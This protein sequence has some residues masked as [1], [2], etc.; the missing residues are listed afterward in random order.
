GNQ[1]SFSAGSG[2]T[3]LPGVSTTESPYGGNVTSLTDKTGGLV[4]GS[5]GKTDF[6]YSGNQS[7]FSAGSGGTGLPGGSSTESHYGGNATSLTDKTG[8]LVS[9]STGKTDFPYGGNQSSF[10]AGSGG[11]GLPGGSSTES[12]YGCDD[13]YEEIYVDFQNFT[14]NEGY[15]TS[16]FTSADLL[17]SESPN[18]ETIC[19]CFNVTTGKYY[20]QKIKLC[21][22]SI[23]NYVDYICPYNFNDDI[24][25]FGV[26]ILVIP[27]NSL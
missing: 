10:S 7:S 27:T 22:I 9:G 1:S 14:C 6:P 12:P 3:G 16:K 21:G 24:V 17:S 19:G 26:I 4:S 5:T 15:T 25:V 11:T 8:G 20:F 18:V 13:D 23:L 2:G